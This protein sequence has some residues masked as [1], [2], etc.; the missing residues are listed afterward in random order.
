MRVTAL[1]V[2]SLANAASL[3]S[4]APVEKYDLLP[5]AVTCTNYAGQAAGR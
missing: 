3:I 2:A 4:A 1:A 5:R